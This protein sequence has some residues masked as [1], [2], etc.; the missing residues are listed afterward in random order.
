MFKPRVI[1][2]LLLK[3]KGLVKSVGF[4]NHKYIGDAINAV[5]IFNDFKT[6]EII[7]LDILATKENR[8]ISL[9]FIKIVIK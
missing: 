1:P 5:K 7:F 8:C 3:G 6:D 9:N 2:V 4:K